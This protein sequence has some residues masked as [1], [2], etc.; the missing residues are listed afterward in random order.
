MTE[1]GLILQVQIEKNIEKKIVQYFKKWNKKV[2][3]D[4]FQTKHETER[5]LLLNIVI[6]E[7]KVTG[8]E[9]T[10]TILCEH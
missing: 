7:V 10:V 5:S 4:G 3:N 8:L 9:V 2:V 1:E 6:L